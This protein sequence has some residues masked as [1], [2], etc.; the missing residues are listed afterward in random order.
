MILQAFCRFRNLEITDNNTVISQAAGRL[1][2]ILNY[3][4][5]VLYGIIFRDLNLFFD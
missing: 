5:T 2:F 4:F 3:Q 1:L